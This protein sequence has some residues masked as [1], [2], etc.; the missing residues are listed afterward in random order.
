MSNELLKSAEDVLS[1]PVNALIVSGGTT[2]SG[3]SLLLVWGQTALGC[4]AAVAGLYLTY[5][6]TKNTIAR[7]RREKKLFRAQMALAEKELKKGR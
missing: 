1:R 2:G 6:V 7:E 4:I 3:V 5:V